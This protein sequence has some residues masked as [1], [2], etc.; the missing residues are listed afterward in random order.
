MIASCSA[1]TCPRTHSVVF[2]VPP[3]IRNRRSSQCFSTTLRPRFVDST[4]LRAEHV[5]SVASAQSALGGRFP[6]AALRV[7]RSSA[8]SGGRSAAPAASREFRRRASL[9]PR[10]VPPERASPSDSAALGESRG[11]AEDLGGVTSVA[12]G[13]ESGRGG[14]SAE[15]DGGG[16][17]FEWGVAE[18][19]G[20]AQAGGEAEGEGWD[21][22]FATWQSEEGEGG[23]DL[24]GGW[25][26]DEE[27]TKR[28][29]LRN[30]REI[31]EE[32]AFLVG[33]EILE[34]R[35]FLVG[36]EESLAE[37]SQLVETA[38]LRVVGSTHQRVASPNPRTYIGAGKVEEVRAAVAGMGVETVVFD[39]ELSAGVYTCWMHV[40]WLC[41]AGMGVETV[42]FD[43][44]LSAG[45]CDRTALI[46][47]RPRDL[48]PAS[49][50]LLP[51][52]SDTVS[53]NVEKEFGG[54]LRNLEKEFGG[55][56]RVCDRTALIIDIFS[57]RANTKEATLQVR[58]LHCTCGSTGQSTNG[59]H[60]H[61][62][63]S[64]L[65]AREQGP[66]PKPN[67]Q[68]QRPSPTPKTNA[69]DQRPRPTP[70]TNAQDQRPR[71]TPKTNAQEQRPRP[72]PKT[73]AQD[74]RPRPTPKTNAQ[75]Q[76]P[77]PT[78]KT[79]AQ[80]QRPRPTPKTNAQD[81]RP[82]PTPKTNA[83]DQRPRPTPKT[84]AQ[85][86]RPRPTPK[87]NAQHQRPRPTP[88]TNA[89]H[90]RP[91][92]NMSSPHFNLFLNSSPPGATSPTR[93]PAA[94]PDAHVDASGEVVGLTRACMQLDITPCL[95]FPFSTPHQ[96][97]LAQLEYQLPRLTR[98]WTHLERQ[99]G[100]MVKGMG[101]KQIEVDKRIIRERMAALRRSLTSVREHR[102]QHRDRRAGLPIPVLSLVGYTN[103]GKSTLLNRLT[104]AGVLAEDKLF[105]TL[106]P[107]TRR[108][109]LP[110]G[111]ECLLTDTVGF[112]QK[113]PTQL[114]AAFRATL[115]EITEASVLLHVV[116]VSHPMAAQQVAAVLQVL[117]ELE[118][119]HIPML[120]VLNKVDQVSPG[121]LQQ[122]QRQL[123][124][125][126]DQNSG[127]R[128][129]SA[130]GRESTAG[131][132]ESSAGGR[133]S[134]VGGRDGGGREDW[135]HRMV[136]VS[137][138]TGEGMDRLFEELEK[139]VNGLLVSIE[140]IIPYQEGH[141]LGLV[142]QLGAV[143][144]E[145]HLPEGTLLSAHV[146]LRVAQLLLPY[147]WTAEKFRT[148]D[149]PVA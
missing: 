6:C 97:Q 93:V 131:G 28:F 96:V 104:G 42:V 83:Q 54:D 108:T 25:S 55:D 23:K 149:A 91:T 115:E 14:G 39:D 143:D 45:V 60:S 65:S 46:A 145:E 47:S 124:T 69:Q 49:S 32:R 21:A 120:T 10:A 105:A 141:L 41:G 107:T 127:G 89:Q 125:I 92:P 139:M 85:D 95:P 133:E 59:M 126:L 99:A 123:E 77:R 132:R 66:T 29:R 11:P 52:L 71:P 130:G 61:T 44:E 3:S 113:L 24:T 140:A 144:R 109:Q 81:Q 19:Q 146:P 27:M 106:D 9:A 79:N 30:G 129:S 94:T 82:R 56:V 73:N 33:V 15:D 110:N 90:Q 118:V 117:A 114:V 17:W 119:S 12:R 136:A 13:A 38:G 58:C 134:S 22:T 76:R 74:Q 122:Q 135:R 78:P 103:A 86:Q 128:E 36:V 64:S 7:R 72:T 112:I 4:P 26:S 57:Q 2:C 84:N 98:M 147:R 121:F 51:F 70:K 5:E 18:G 100:G 1:T 142:Y 35:A 50:R 53:C 111:K 63:G 48:S 43:N 148:R 31:L 138:V 116:D 88:K 62:R 80:D 137:A 16:G 102:Q 68:D 20:E 37:L 87:T 101:E 75:D 40:S 8:I 67:A 34:E